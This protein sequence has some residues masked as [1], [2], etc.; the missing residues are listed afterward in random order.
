MGMDQLAATYGH[1]LMAVGRIAGFGRRSIS[2]NS[3]NIVDEK[4]SVLPW[5]TG[6][7]IRDRTFKSDDGKNLHRVAGALSV[8]AKATGLIGP[9]HVR[10]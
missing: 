8:R 9:G 7:E 2:K 1:R 4:G 6:L 10:A 5:R 3:E